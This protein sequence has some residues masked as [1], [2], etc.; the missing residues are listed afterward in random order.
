[1]CDVFIFFVSKSS[2]VTFNVIS[3]NALVDSNYIIPGHDNPDFSSRGVSQE[4]SACIK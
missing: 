2:L 3:L 1:M 4:A